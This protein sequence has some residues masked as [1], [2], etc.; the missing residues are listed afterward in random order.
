MDTVKS[1]E[2]GAERKRIRPG[3]HIDSWFDATLETSL[4]DTQHSSK[5]IFGWDEFY[6]FGFS[7]V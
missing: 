4:E 5:K 1:D 3:D 6:V 2:S 7:T